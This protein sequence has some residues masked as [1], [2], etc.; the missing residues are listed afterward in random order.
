MPRRRGGRAARA[1]GSGARPCGALLTQPRRAPPRWNG[2]GGVRRATAPTGGRQAAPRRSPAP[3]VH[4]AANNVAAR[5]PD[6]GGG[7]EA[8]RRPRRGAPS[9]RALRAARRGRTRAQTPACADGR[10]ARDWPWRRGRPD[11]PVNGKAAVPSAAEGGATGQPAA[12]TPPT[13]PARHAR[14]CRPPHQRP[15]APL[16]A[17]NRRSRA[18]APRRQPNR[19]AHPLCAAEAPQRA[20]ATRRG[21]CARR[22]IRLPRAPC[23]AAARRQRGAPRPM[24]VAA[25]L[26][27]SEGVQTESSQ[28]GLPRWNLVPCAGRPGVARRADATKPALCGAG[29]SVLQLAAPWTAAGRHPSPAARVETHL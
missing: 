8:G 18:R 27:P 10:P 23:Q 24:A 21:A 14:C 9:H 13:P 20:A 5:A 15:A 25:R 2:W 11:A 22:E 4:D 28:R 17:R 26:V 12:G 19:P 16:G 1:R 3:A 7:D 29:P 6:D